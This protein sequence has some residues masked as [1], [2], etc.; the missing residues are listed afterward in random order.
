[1]NHPAAVMSRRAFVATGLLVASAA[2]GQIGCSH[3]SQ[4]ANI[5]DESGTLAQLSWADIAAAAQAIAACGSRQEALEA[6]RL[7]GLIDDAGRLDPSGSKNI[8]LSDGRIAPTQI[9][10][11]YA[12]TATAGGSVGLTFAITEALDQRGINTD[13]VNTGG[14]EQSALRAWLANEGL[15]LLPD[16]VATSIIAVDKLTNNT[17]AAGDSSAVTVTRDRLWVPSLIELY[18]AADWFE[19]D[20]AWCNDI[21]NAEGHQYQRFSDG[22]ITASSSL[23]SEGILKATYKGKPCEWWT[24]TPRPSDN[25]YFAGV[26]RDGT[27]NAIG[28]LGGYSAGAIACFCL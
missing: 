11:V 4:A 9:I 17:G 8:S 3:T 16:E 18:G 7:Y 20:Q 24:R 14:W 5:P 6:A 27:A 25:V 23:S 13:H 28:Y 19:G 1:M 2:V 22:G 10:G 15:A 21:V 26:Y 12:D